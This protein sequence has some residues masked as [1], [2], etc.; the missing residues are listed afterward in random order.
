MR[1]VGAAKGSGSSPVPGTG[2]DSAAG[3]LMRRTGSGDGKLH[4]GNLR[5][6]A[7]RIQDKEHRLRFPRAESLPY[8]KMIIACL[9]H[10]AGSQVS[11]T[12][13]IR[14]LHANCEA[15][16][17]SRTSSASTAIQSRN[18]PPTS[19]RP[20][21][22]SLQR[23]SLSP[24]HKTQ[25]TQ[26]P[27]AVTSSSKPGPPTSPGPADSDSE[28]SSSDYDPPAQSRILRRPPRYSPYKPGLPEDAE[29]ED[30]DDPFLPFSNTNTQ[31]PSKHHDP[32]ATLREDPG[33]TTRHSLPKRTNEAMQQSQNSDSS[34][35]SSI[36][37]STN[38]PVNTARHHQSS[39][40]Q[41]PGPFSPRRMAELAGRSPGSKGKGRDGSDGAPSMG[42][43]FS[44]LDGKFPT[45]QAS[46][47]DSC[48]HKYRRINH[49]VSSGR[50]F[51]KQYAGW[52]YGK[53]NEYN[54]PS[55]TQPISELNCIAFKREHTAGCTAPIIRS[56]VSDETG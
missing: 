37:G 45:I 49:S 8:P 30:E 12:G 22:A 56:L 17:M 50:G 43:S 33:Q 31:Q 26:R 19:P 38:S 15:P 1:R 23:R 4:H 11:R 24:A 9:A 14:M 55:S 32:S 51:G 41:R 10:Q 13:K 21:K 39:Q 53:P 44:D 34:A 46:S 29:E 40:G 36:P 3:E 52:R 16:P 5:S 25:I 35:S 27:R 20:A 48:S 54:Q 7:H 28:D 18:L 6:E 47:I 2:S 42:S